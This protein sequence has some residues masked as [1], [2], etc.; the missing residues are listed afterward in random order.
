MKCPILEIGW[1]QVK[2]GDKG[3]SSDCLKEGC[4]WWSKRLEAC[5]VPALAANLMGLNETMLHLANK[6]PHEEQFRG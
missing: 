3:V 6:M 4:A 1:M 5:S 2:V